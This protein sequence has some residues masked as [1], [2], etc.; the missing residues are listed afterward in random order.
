ME[1]LVREQ[2]CNRRHFE[3]HLYDNHGFCKSTININLKCLIPFASERTLFKCEL[4]SECAGDE[5]KLICVRRQQL[6]HRICEIMK[7]KRSDLWMLN[8]LSQIY[9]INLKT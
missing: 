7:D 4:V 8:Q 5:K 3:V 2:H 9:N 1:C 6:D